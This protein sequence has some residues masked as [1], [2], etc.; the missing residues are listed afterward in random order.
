M[1][2]NYKLQSASNLFRWKIYSEDKSAF[3]D[4]HILANEVSLRTH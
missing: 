1:K 3:K 4:Q 2:C